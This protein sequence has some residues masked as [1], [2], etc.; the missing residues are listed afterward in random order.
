MLF[1][2]AD[3]DVAPLITALNNAMYA[4]QIS[5]WRREID[6]WGSK[7]EWCGVPNREQPEEVEQL[8]VELGGVQ[9]F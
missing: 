4:G 3:K 1:F 6:D 9:V 5:E 2:S 7:F 8:V